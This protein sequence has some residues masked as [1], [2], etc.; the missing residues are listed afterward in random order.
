MLARF[1]AE[2]VEPFRDVLRSFDPLDVSRAE[3]GSATRS[4]CGR[5]SLTGKVA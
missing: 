1:R 4:P 2:L 3:K 5:L